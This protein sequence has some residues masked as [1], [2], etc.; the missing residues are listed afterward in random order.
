MQ[1]YLNTL[2]NR[3]EIS[4]DEKKSIRPKFA[5]IG[6]SNG[7]PKTHKKFEDLPP[8]RPMVDFTNTPCYS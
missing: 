5:Q 8:F 7:L 1:K 4:N 3:G 2:F 6:R